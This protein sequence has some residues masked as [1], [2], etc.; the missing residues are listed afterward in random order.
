[1]SIKEKRQ[2]RDNVIW[3][4]FIS[5]VIMISGQI[6]GMTIPSYDKKEAYMHTLMSYANFIGIWIM[7]I[8]PILVFRKN[9]YILKYLTMDKKGNTIKNLFIGLLVGFVLN[10]V[11]AIV[12]Y[13]HGDIV[14]IFNKFE[15]LPVIGLF[16]AVFVQSSAEEALCRGFMYQRLLKSNPNPAFAIIVNSLFFACIHLLNDGINALAFY[17]L[18]ITG[19]FF[20]MAVYRYNSLWM[21]MGLHATWNF[22]QSILLGLPN[23][24]SSFPYSIF[25]LDTARI[26]SSFAY[27]TGFGLEGTILSAGLMTLCCVAMY[28]HGRK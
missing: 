8:V 27:D 17:D 25:V 18:F 24:G 7:V 13:L 15:L 14:L 10:A 26:Q 22:T 11:C 19:V 6:L 12:A 4:V 3:I 20:S 21:A 9:R 1:M 28:M 16:L 2:W 23:S 5:I